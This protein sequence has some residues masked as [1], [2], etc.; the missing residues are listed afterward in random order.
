MTAYP[1]WTDWAWGLGL[2]AVAAAL[3]APEL[4]ALLCSR[5]LRGEDTA[6]G[7]PRQAQA[8]HRLPVEWLR[9]QAAGLVLLRSR[10]DGDDG[11][12]APLL[13]RSL[14]PHAPPPFRSPVPEPEFQSHVHVAAQASQPVRPRHSTGGLEQYSE[15]QLDR[16]QHQ[17]DGRRLQ[18]PVLEEP[19]QLVEGPLRWPH[20]LEQLQLL[21]QHL[22]QT[23][24]P[25][26]PQQHAAH[27]RSLG[28]AGVPDRRD[29]VKGRGS[30]DDD[31]G[32]L[33][34]PVMHRSASA[35]AEATWAPQDP[36]AAD[37]LLP[38]RGRAGNAA[39]S[40]SVGAGGGGRSAALGLQLAAASAFALRNMPQAS[41]RL[42]TAEDGSGVGGGGSVMAAG[43][44]GA[45]AADA[46][47]EV[48]K[49]GG[50]TAALL[51]VAAAA[52]T[53]TGRGERLLSDPTGWATSVAGGGSRGK[54]RGAGGP[55]SAVA[56][57]SYASDGLA[58]LARLASLA[59][60]APDS[61][62][63]AGAKGSPVQKPQPKLEASRLQPLRPLIGP[64]ATAGAQLPYP[65]LVQGSSLGDGFAA[66]GLVGREPLG[67]G[68]ANTTAGAATPPPSQLPILDQPLPPLALQGIPELARM[69]A[70]APSA[71]PGS[72]KEQQ[73][74]LSRLPAIAAATRDGD[75]DG[76][77]SGSGSGAAGSCL[78]RV[79]SG[80]P[81]VTAGGS[82][83][84][85]AAADAAAAAVAAETAAAG[86]DAE[87]EP[88]ERE[89]DIR[90]HVMRCGA[91]AH[92]GEL[93]ALLDSHAAAAALPEAPFTRDRSVSG[94]QQESAAAG[95]FTVEVDLGGKATTPGPDTAAAAAAADPDAPGVSKI[96][97]GA[98][99]A[100]APIRVRRGQRLVLRNGS[101]RACVV[102]ESGATAQLEQVQ[103]TAA[104]ASGAAAAAA[105]AVVLVQ[106]A[107]A[108]GSGA[109]ENTCCVLVR[110]GGGA[111]LQCCELSG[112]PN[113]GLSVEGLGS[114][115]RATSTTARG[116][117]LG[118]LASAGGVLE[119]CG[120]LA[121]QGGR[122]TV[123][124]ESLAEGNDS[125]F[126]AS[127]AGSVLVT[128]ARCE[129]VGAAGCGFLAEEGAELAAARGCVALGGAAHGFCARTGGRLVLSDG[130][131]SECNA[132]R[133]FCDGSQAGEID[134]AEGGGNSGGGRGEAA[135]AGGVKGGGRGHLQLGV[136]CVSMGNL[137]PHA[138]L[139]AYAWSNRTCKRRRTDQCMLL[140][141]I[142]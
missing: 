48:G 118:F 121:A 87:A 105:A 22:L 13:M 94:Q 9:G 33:Q 127:G 73:P 100:A 66:A 138:W 10:S 38:S 5:L 136:G 31:S 122:L 124:D 23:S 26:P 93:Q 7:S 45:A 16:H 24:P 99:G 84:L 102:V 110:A 14:P 58:L 37:D 64:A 25:L 92:V 114:S 98:E 4:G 28:L 47:A 11:A 51:G 79:A 117:G 61:P 77:I 133:G 29:N 27:W 32:R 108:E 120:F 18:Q 30:H 115:A 128:G 35:A 88:A 131:Q 34:P 69:L 90:R 96:G 103:L 76:V 36:D 86:A 54:A 21:H 97:A 109:D 20:L 3:L 74:V 81:S 116:C 49:S 43:K 56:G 57:A 83:A 82:A 59:D 125:G 62:F 130:C 139:H 137:E 6:D 68:V 46:S 123:G 129:A 112:A 1:A 12:A 140:S 41:S 141:C 19:Q 70:A 39:G 106:A 50:A 75:A 42:N 91:P 132:G 135:E 89:P 71:A 63:A 2:G 113:A 119:G 80:Q 85:G 95:V 53:S 111:V 72:G 55:D 52:G 8:D 134:G 60:E 67:G 104:P 78:P 126:A 15:H 17:Q 44:R 142:Q 40:G 101:L 107:A 65:G